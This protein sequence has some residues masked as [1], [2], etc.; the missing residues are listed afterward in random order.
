MDSAASESD[1]NNTSTPRIRLA[2]S[3]MLLHRH[4]FVPPKTLHGVQRNGSV[5]A[6]TGRISP[7]GSSWVLEES[8]EAWLK[9]HFRVTEGFDASGDDLAVWELVGP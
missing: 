9:Q 6:P 8:L 2:P 7:S 4:V 1:W 3:V 5:L